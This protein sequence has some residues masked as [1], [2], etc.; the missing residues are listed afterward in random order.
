MKDRDESP[1]SASICSVTTLLVSIMS[2]G[3]WAATESAIMRFRS[4]S[5]RL[6]P[7]AE[8][9][10]VS[11]A[12]LLAALLFPLSLEGEARLDISARYSPERSRVIEGGEM[13]D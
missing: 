13:D 5:R 8:L 4:S 1:R 11:E 3:N 6:D 9:E 2:R 10:S 12:S 7:A